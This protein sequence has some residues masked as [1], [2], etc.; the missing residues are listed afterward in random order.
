MGGIWT[1]EDDDDEVVGAD[2]RDGSEM[3]TGAEGT[4][5]TRGTCV[6][7]TSSAENAL[8][9]SAGPRVRPVGA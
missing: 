6:G 4:C 9:S 8:G 3:D 1:D 2:Q 5:R 7:M